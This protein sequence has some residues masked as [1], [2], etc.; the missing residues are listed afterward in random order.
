[1]VVAMVS[2][3]AAVIPPCASRRS[4]V[5]SA[6]NWR[7]FTAYSNGSPA[8]LTRGAAGLPVIGTTPR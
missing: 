1:M 4:S 8:P 5:A 3:I 7:I 6:G 2:T